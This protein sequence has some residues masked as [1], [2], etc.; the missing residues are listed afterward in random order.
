[1][2]YVGVVTAGCLARDEHDVIGVDTDVAKVDLVNAGKSARPWAAR[3][4]F[5]SWS[6]A[7]RCCPDRCAASSCRSSS[8]APA[9]AR[10]ST[11]ASATTPSASA[12]AAPVV[13]TNVET[14]EMI[15]HVDNVWHALKVCFANEIGNLCK[16]RGLDSHEAMDI[17]C[18]DTKLNL[19]PCYLKPGFAF[20]GS[21]L[22]KDVRALTYKARTLDPELPVLNSVLASNER[23]IGE[24]FR[25]VTGFGHRRVGILGLS[26]KPGNR[27]TSQ[28]WANHR[29]SG[30]DHGP[31][32]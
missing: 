1:L 8:S 13:R 9:G 18:R 3:A 20:G 27:E 5:T 16:A 25:M 29:G 15:K 19:S 31:P 22:P 4:A 26:F 30:P 2:G 28:K 23:Q 12:K 7:G 14:A 24:A 11:S 6:A 32:K 17:F 21:C 10:E